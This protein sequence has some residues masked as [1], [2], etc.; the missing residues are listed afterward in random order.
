MKNIAKTAA[1]L[2][3]SL[4]MLISAACSNQKA[5]YGAYADY[6]RVG[7][8][9]SW[10]YNYA[11]V[12]ELAEACDLAAYVSIKDRRLDSSSEIVFTIYTAEIRESLYGEEKDEIKIIMTGGIVEDEKKI[13]EISDDPLMKAG[14]EYFIFA[15][16]NESGTYTVLSGSQG[17]FEIVD[18]KVCSLNVSIA[19]VAKVNPYSNIK[20]DKQSKDEFYSEIREYVK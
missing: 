11:S 13:Y 6:E 3:L 4:V 2:C 8:S 18:G 15:K 17:R 7:M 20:V 1:V 9:A 10:T 16:K 5:G 12:K 14:D 19:E